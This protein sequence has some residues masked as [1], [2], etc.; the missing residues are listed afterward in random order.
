MR[1]SHPCLRGVENQ[2][3]ALISDAQNQGLPLLR[4]Q[5]QPSTFTKHRKSTFHWNLGFKFFL[6]HCDSSK[7]RGKTELIMP[8]LSSTFSVK[9]IF[10]FWKAS[11]IK[12]LPQNLRTSVTQRCSWP[13]WLQTN[14]QASVRW[15]PSRNCTLIHSSSILGALWDSGPGSPSHSQLPKNYPKAHQMPTLLPHSGGKELVS[16]NILLIVSAATLGMCYF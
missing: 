4:G 8:F 16:Q 7:E 9:Y 10:T 2:S 6:F 15:L 11:L 14:T 12:R 1:E 13:W 3:R 5:R